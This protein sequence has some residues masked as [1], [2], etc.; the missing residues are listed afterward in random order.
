V[1]ARHPR[2]VKPGRRGF[3]ER[4]TH[5][6]QQSWVASLIVGQLGSLVVMGENGLMIIA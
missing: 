6:W 2:Q 5:A 4:G 3:E 1:T